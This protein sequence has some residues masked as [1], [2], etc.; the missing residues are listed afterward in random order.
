MLKVGTASLVLEMI[1]PVA[2]D[3]FCW[4]TRFAPSA[5]SATT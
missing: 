5:R 1:G 2:F 4:T 3:D